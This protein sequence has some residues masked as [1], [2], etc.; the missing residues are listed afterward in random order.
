MLGASRLTGSSMV[1]PVVLFSAL[2]CMAWDSCMRSE[3]LREII[4]LKIDENGIDSGAALACFT[5]S[6]FLCLCNSPNSWADFGKT[7]P[8]S[9]QQ[10]FCRYPG[11]AIGFAFAS[12]TCLSRITSHCDETHLSGSSVEQSGATM[13][14]AHFLLPLQHLGTLG[15]CS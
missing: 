1:L 11:S 8:L 6:S 9:Q 13:R 15:L 3:H 10:S 7:S 4:P 14:S 12:L 5:L 2:R